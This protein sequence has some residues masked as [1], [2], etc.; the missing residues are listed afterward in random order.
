MWHAVH[1]AWGGSRR[2]QP[3]LPLR[4]RLYDGRTVLLA[5]AHPHLPY[6]RST[7]TAAYLTH[8]VARM[9]LVWHRGRCVCAAV[10]WRCGARTRDYTLLAEPNSVICPLCTLQRPPR[11]RAIR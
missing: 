10:Q 7:H 9:V 8:A 1:F 4:Y 6:G 11:E 3:T 2:W 5:E